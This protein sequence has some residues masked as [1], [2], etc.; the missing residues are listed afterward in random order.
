MQRPRTDRAELRFP[1]ATRALTQVVLMAPHPV[2]QAVLAGAFKRAEAAFNR[3]DMDV[4]FAAFAPDVEYEPPPQLPG[5]RPLRGRPA[6]FGYWRG[7]F[8]EFEDNRIE[9]VEVVETGQGTIR[10]VAR[11]H[12]RHRDGGQP[13]DYEILQTTELR[14]GLVVRQRNEARRPG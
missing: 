14:G 1:R 3:G 10:R 8:E 5:A 4:V 6:V 11:L 7:I 13:L 12:H 2:R 9:N